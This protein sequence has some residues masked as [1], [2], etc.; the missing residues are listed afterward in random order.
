MNLKSLTK[1]VPIR[2]KLRIEQ[3]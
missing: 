3:V 1:I 2:F